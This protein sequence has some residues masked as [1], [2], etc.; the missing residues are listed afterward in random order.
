MT[1][2]SSQPRELPREQRRRL[3]A[4]L[5]R[6]AAQVDDPEMHAQLLEEVVLANICVARSIAS[7]YRSRGV[8]TEDLEQVANAALVRAVQQFDGTRAS[9]FLSFAVPS[10]RGEL[11]RYFRDHGWMVRPPRRVQELQSRVIEERDRLQVDGRRTATDAEIAERLDVPEA[12]VTEALRA[13][14]CF[15]PSSL[16]AP[17]SDDAGATVGE[18]LADAD[19][20]SDSDAAEARVMLRPVVRRLSPR[21]QELLR[22]RFFEELT[23]QEIADKFQVTQ[24]QVSRLL[25]RVLGDLRGS[26][27]EDPARSA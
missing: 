9:D 16:D 10:I 27:T 7:R 4:G 25:S 19:P 20:L 2:G 14:G 21:D 17:L 13:E 1:P 8:P 18:A 3:T 11:R 15:T 5:L 23:Q 26:L 6:Q 12:D 22:L 24:T